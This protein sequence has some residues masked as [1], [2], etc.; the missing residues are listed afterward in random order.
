MVH[1]LA[2]A[3]VSGRVREGFTLEDGCLEA[4]RG[5]GV[6]AGFDGREN[7]ADLGDLHAVVAQALNEVE[8]LEMVLVVVGG[9]GC[10]L[11]WRREQ[12]FALVVMNACAG[13]AGPFDQLLH[14]QESPPFTHSAYL[15]YA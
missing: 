10:G 5:F 3:V 14:L 6:A 9:I 12:A 15:Y 1:E 7:S 11:V 4:E 8:A 2:A 13:H